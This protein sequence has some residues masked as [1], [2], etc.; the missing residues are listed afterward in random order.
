MNKDHII[1]L[2]EHES[3]PLLGLFNEID[4]FDMAQLA[5]K[6]PDWVDASSEFYMTIGRLI[7]GG[8]VGEPRNDIYPETQRLADR[9]LL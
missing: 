1:S 2:L 8:N 4:G 6:N 7:Y 3:I 5:R 9:R